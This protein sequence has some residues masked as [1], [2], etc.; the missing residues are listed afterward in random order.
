MLYAD[1]EA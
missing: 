1:A